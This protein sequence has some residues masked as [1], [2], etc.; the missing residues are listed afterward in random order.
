MDLLFTGLPPIA[1]TAPPPTSIANN[2]ETES[3]YM[4]RILRNQDSDSAGPPR[5]SYLQQQQQQPPPM[6][7]QGYQ[8]LNQVLTTLKIYFLRSATTEDKFEW[9]QNVCSIDAYK[10]PSKLFWTAQFMNFNTGFG[11]LNAAI[12]CP[13]MNWFGRIMNRFQWEREGRSWVIYIRKSNQSCCWCKLAC[14]L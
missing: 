12:I 3:I 14:G 6:A 13:N 4:P 5:P 2:Y 8:Q 1:S 7:A 11:Y 9:V 10:S